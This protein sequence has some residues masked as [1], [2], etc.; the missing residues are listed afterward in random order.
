[1]ASGYDEFLARVE[2]SLSE[3]ER[4]FEDLGV[5]H[6]SLPSHHPP[7][8]PVKHKKPL[9]L[10]E[11]FSNDG[12][13][14]FE[15]WVEKVG[16]VAKI[17]SWSDVD[18]MQYVPLRL[19]ED[20]FRVYSDMTCDERATF[21]SFCETFRLRGCPKNVDTFKA[22]LAARKKRENE[23][24]AQLCSDLRRLLIRAYPNTSS[25]VREELGV[26]YFLNAI[27]DKDVRLQVRRSSPR[28]LDDAL[29]VALAE[30]SYLSL[31]KSDKRQR[32]AVA[33]TVKVTNPS[34]V[35][36]MTELRQKV[37]GLSKMLEEALTELK[38]V[39]GGKRS[40]RYCTFCKKTGHTEDYCWTKYPEKKKGN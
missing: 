23:T 36:E 38:N 6:R 39:R 32:S 14:D 20:A 25:L 40:E 2:G 7:S 34:H 16:L 33:S 9:V 8:T 28:S 29:A 10:P 35:E 1:M 5:M 13:T 30:D 18:V 4:S 22:E 37:D 15:D 19:K 17:N 3:L 26:D 27:S 24:Y 12:K 21:G 31:E 11:F